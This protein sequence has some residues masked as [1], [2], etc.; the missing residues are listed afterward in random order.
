MMH[1]ATVAQSI[2]EI[3][4]AKCRQTPNAT[5]ALRVHVIIGEFRNIDQ[6]SLQFAFESLRGLYDACSAC[7]L[8][9]DIVKAQAFCREEQHRYYPDFSRAYRCDVC[10]SGIGSLL[11][12]EELDVV[13]ITLEGVLDKKEKQRDQKENEDHARVGR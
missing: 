8:E 6:E 10:E 3:V 11:C 1:E 9:V 5:R 13:N 12:G 7:Q 2:L 4:S